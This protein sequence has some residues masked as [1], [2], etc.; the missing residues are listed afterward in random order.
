[1]AQCL[2]TQ[3]E[4]GE[5]AAQ[6]ALFDQGLHVLGELPVVVLA[7]FQ[8]AHAVAD[9]DQRV[10]REI[11]ERADFVG[12][13]RGEI[14]VHAAERQV[15]TK[16]LDVAAQRLDDGAVFGLFRNF[17]RG[18][19]KALEHFFAPAVREGG[20][21][22]RRG[23]DGQGFDVLR[24]ALGRHVEFAHRVDLVVEK[25]DAHGR[26]QRRPDV[27]NAA[28]QRELADALDR[29]RARVA[30]FDKLFRECVQVKAVAER[31]VRHRAAQRVGRERSLHQTIDRR[32]QDWR[33][34]G[35]KAAQ[36]ADALLLPAVGGEHAVA[37]LPFARE[38][39]AHVLAEQLVQVA[40]HAVCLVF[41]RADDQK[42]A[43]CLVPHGSGELRAV[44]T[45][46][47]RHGDGRCARVEREQQLAHLGKRCERFIEFVHSLHHAV[48]LLPQRAKGQIRRSRGGSCPWL[49]IILLYRLLAKS[50]CRFFKFWRQKAFSRCNGSVRRSRR[51]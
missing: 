15:V 46:K 18:A 33:F 41:V 2:L 49:S 45:R 4:R 32:D 26:A 37:Q 13:A 38:Q 21:H 24:A 17:L 16:P 43:L 11:V 44:H 3:R 25:L 48:S 29:F 27:E 1:M 14:P 19:P 51:R 36:R 6:N 20:Q 7:A 8:N 42:R 31:N 10:G 12:V 9:G 23:Q 22:L 5:F 34:S 28:A 35:G 40:R 50:L 47:A 39:Q 30:A